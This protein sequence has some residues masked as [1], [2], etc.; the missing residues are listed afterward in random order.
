MSLTREEINYI[1]DTMA[2][3]YESSF[4]VTAG[5]TV[6]LRCEAG[7][8][9]AI[10]RTNGSIEEYIGCGEIVSKHEV[11]EDVAAMWEIVAD[12]YIL[13][14]DSAHGLGGALTEFGQEA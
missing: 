11:R 5:S 13:H 3:E 10:E 14:L 8:R 12:L 2:K 4:P 6:T 9:I 1:R 7:E